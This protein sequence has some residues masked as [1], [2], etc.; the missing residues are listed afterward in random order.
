MQ[1]IV[2]AVGVESP[3]GLTQAALSPLGSIARD[4]L[5]KR[6]ETQHQ[7][8]YICTSIHM[9][10]MENLF[11]MRKLGSCMKGIRKY[12]MNKYKFNLILINVKHITKTR[13]GKRREEYMVLINVKHITVHGVHLSVSDDDLNP[14]ASYLEVFWFELY[15]WC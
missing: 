9:G 15:C 13:E 11:L 7:V 4:L 5:L 12:Y 3:L 1:R 14:Q 2:V 10:M 8:S 6:V